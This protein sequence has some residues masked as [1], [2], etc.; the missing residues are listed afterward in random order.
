MTGTLAQR[1]AAEI[2]ERALSVVFGS[3][4]VTALRADSPLAAVG[5]RSGDLVC[6]SD[7]VAAESSARGVTCVLDDVA[8]ADVATVG[9]LVA[10]VQ[11]GAELLGDGA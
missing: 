1:T 2:T 7:A 6:V 3:A 9:D 11:A 5:L 10:A 8:L 4:A